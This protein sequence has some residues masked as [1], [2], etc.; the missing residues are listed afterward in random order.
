MV[1][2]KP[3]LT[4]LGAAAGIWI[5]LKA[6]GKRREAAIATRR[7]VR[8]PDQMKKPDPNNGTTVFKQNATD[9][10]IEQALA[11]VMV[12]RRHVIAPALIN[13]ILPEDVSAPDGFSGVEKSGTRTKD[14]VVPRS[15]EMVVFWT[16]KGGAHRHT[17]VTRAS[18]TRIEFNTRG[19]DGDTIDR[20]AVPSRNVTLS[21]DMARVLD[22]GPPTVVEL[23]QFGDKE[24]GW[25]NWADLLSRIGYVD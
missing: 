25:L 5:S 24:L 12:L 13:A 7:A 22:R 23:V 10:V 4:L 11:D 21:V 9:P 8:V 16:A 17:F 3:L 15:D 2:I 19:F 6:S 1:P 14:H 20:I 18:A